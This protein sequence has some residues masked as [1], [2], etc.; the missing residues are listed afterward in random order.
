MATIG[1]EAFSYYRVIGRAVSYERSAPA[2]PLH[3]AGVKARDPDPLP[4]QEK[5]TLKVL[6]TH[7]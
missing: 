3:F 2:E 4:S 7:T 6:R 5:I 1:L